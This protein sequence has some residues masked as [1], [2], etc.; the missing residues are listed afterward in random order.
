MA[1]HDA[2]SPFYNATL[3]AISLTRAD[4]QPTPET[5]PFAVQSE[6]DY[7]FNVTNGDQ[8]NKDTMVSSATVD[9][10]PGDR[11]FGPNDFN[12]NVA[13][14]T[15]TVHLLPGNYSLTTELRS[16]PGAYLTI[17]ISNLD[18]GGLPK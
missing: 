11:V 5:V 13:L 2:N 16:E 7:V 17:V 14:L 3:L 18:F 10:A 4:G 1:S 6:G 9:F 8:V 12:K 15:K